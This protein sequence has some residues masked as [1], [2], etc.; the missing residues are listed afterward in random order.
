M[1]ISNNL[2]YF[3]IALPSHNK[4]PRKELN[5]WKLGQ[6]FFANF[7]L[8]YELRSDTHMTFS[9]RV[10]GGLVRKK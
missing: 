7:E 5:A 3:V 9:L 10:A 4:N 8:C 6:I 2:L 1:T